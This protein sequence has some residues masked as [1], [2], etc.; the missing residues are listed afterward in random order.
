[1]TTAQYISVRP[2]RPKSALAAIS[3]KA[4]GTPEKASIREYIWAAMIRKQTA[5]VTSPVSTSTRQ[6]EARVRVRFKS[7][8]MSAPM[9]PT[10][11]ASTGVKRVV[12]EI[13]Q[14]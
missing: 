7:P 4:L 3:P 1:M 10:A 12:A 9:A 11:P 14:S 5:A 6:S 13:I 8:M 2:R